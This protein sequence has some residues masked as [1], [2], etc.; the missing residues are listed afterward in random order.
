MWPLR[1]GDS[2]SAPGWDHC[3]EVDDSGHQ[4]TA[5]GADKTSSELALMRLK[6]EAENL[7][8]RYDAMLKEKIERTKR[9]Y[10][11]GVSVLLIGFV[12]S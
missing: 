3:S 8:K 2:S 7:S 9:G 4:N 1:H 12:Q 11:M 5:T 6:E 10:L